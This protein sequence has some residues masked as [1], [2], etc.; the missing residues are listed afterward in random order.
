MVSEIMNLVARWSSIPACDEF[1]F[2]YGDISLSV[3]VSV[4]CEPGGRMCPAMPREDL[5]WQIRRECEIVKK[6]ALKAKWMIPWPYLEPGG[7]GNF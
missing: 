2:V 4:D 3:T 7:G 6:S 1:T 5:L